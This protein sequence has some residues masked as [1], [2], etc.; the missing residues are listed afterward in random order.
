VGGFR[1]PPNADAVLFFCR[2]VLP[3]VRR[4]LPDVTVT[5]VGDA[6]P[7]EV[8]ALSSPAITVTGWVPDV[9]PYL[10]SH[11]VAIAPL[12]YGAGLKGKIVQAMGAGLPVVTTTVGAEG[13][14]LLHGGTALIADSPEGFAEAIAR[15]CTDQDL[16]ARLSRNGVAHARA[17]WDPGEVTRRLLETMARL[18]TLRPKRLGAMDRLLIRGWVRFE[19]SG[20][21]TGIDRLSTLLGWYCRRL[22]RTRFSGHWSRISDKV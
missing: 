20:V 12:R 3:L 14:E 15:L 19:S 9:E 7:K 16:H 6:P 8:R 13:M 10:A 4:A 2:Q 22:S 5:L 17:R 21:P 1:H 11:C 18:P